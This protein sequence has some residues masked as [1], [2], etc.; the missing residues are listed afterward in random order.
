MWSCKNITLICG[1]CVN[2]LFSSHDV[3]MW[4]PHVIYR[5]CPHVESTCD[6]I[7]LLFHFY[8][9]PHMMSTCGV[10]M[11]FS[12][13][14]FSFLLINHMWFPHMITCKL[15]MWLPHMIIHMWFKCSHVES[16]CDFRIWSPHVDTPSN[17]MRFTLVMNHTIMWFF[18]HPTITQLCVRACVGTTV[19]ADD[20]YEAS[21]KRNMYVHSMIYES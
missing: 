8:D 16:T 9:F 17:H 2:K 10:H 5:W 3:H 19:T 4:S 13:I 6:L 15:H 12:Y 14:T 1:W 18:T 20:V 7:T 21:C 11:W